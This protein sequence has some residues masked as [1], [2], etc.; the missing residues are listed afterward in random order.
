[1]DNTGLSFFH[2][3][4]YS[5]ASFK[6]YKHFLSE[7]TGKA[8]AYLLVLSLIA[9]IAIS[10]IPV[11]AIAEVIDEMIARYD[12]SVPNFTFEN[13]ELNVD[14]TSPI[15]LSGGP[16]TIIIDTT[17]GTDESILINYDS[18][19][20]FT[21]TKMVQKNYAR[22]QAVNYSNFQGVK[23]DKDSVR[24][25]LPL[26]KKWFLIPMAIM[27]VLFF[28]VSK[29]VSA[30]VLGLGAI[31]VAKIQNVRLVFRDGF[32]LSAYASTLPLILC[33]ILDFLPFAVPFVWVVYYLIALAYL[34]GAVSS[35]KEVPMIEP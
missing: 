6:H 17:G 16:T 9:G 3:I 27:S 13:G 18:A 26:M 25:A 28:I 4:Y 8:V 22:M 1:M 10:V 34:W 2:K 21:K 32:V 14:S 5:I 35:I 7:K 19:I 15:I 23:A 20:L 24:K 30:L 12:E 29:Y 33:T 11:T 31:L